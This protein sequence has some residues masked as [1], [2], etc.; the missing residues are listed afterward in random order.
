M[1]PGKS[2]RK[3]QIILSKLATSVFILMH[4]LY[5]FIM[6]LAYDSR[7]QH[8]KSS[9][10]PLSSIPQLMVNELKVYEFKCSQQ[11]FLGET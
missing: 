7:S 11:P 9:N 5:I 6:L 4:T 1:K 10:L 8:P 2:C 3:Q